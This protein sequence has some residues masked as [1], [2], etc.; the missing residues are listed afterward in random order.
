MLSASMFSKLDAIGRGVRNS[1]RSR[2]LP[3][4][5]MQVIVC[6]DFFQLPPGAN[7]FCV[8]FVLVLPLKDKCSSLHRTALN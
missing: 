7:P 3:F 6:G 4:G 1:G 5:G 8:G 2:H